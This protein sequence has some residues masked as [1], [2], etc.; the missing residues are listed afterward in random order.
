MGKDFTIDDKNTSN[1]N[2]T[3]TELYLKRQTNLA[4]QFT[5]NKL[6]KSFKTK[7]LPQTM[8]TTIDQQYYSYP[9]GLNRIDTA[10]IDNDTTIPPLRV[11]HNQTEW[12]QINSGP[13]TSGIPSHIF[14]RSRD[15]GLFPIPKAAYTITLTG[16]FY[17]RNMYAADYSTGTVAITQNS[18]TVTGTGT[19]FTSEMVGRYLCET[20]SNGEPIGEFYKIGAFVSTTSLTLETV[21]EE[22]SLS[23]ATYLIGESPNL[24]PEVH[25]LIPYRVA[26]IY[27]GT[28]RRSASRAQEFSNFYW[29][30]DWGN[31]N[32]RGRIEGGILGFIQDYAL[33]GSDNSQLLNLNEPIRHDFLSEEWES[34]ST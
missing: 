17:P 19:T 22:S 20:D 34:V 32:R 16:R 24:P 9:P 14:M 27:Y 1:S 13:V 8:S 6:K 3:N 23:G 28:K 25:E 4:V 30:G 15:F 26:S 10:T 21:F 18:A 11:V 12:D 31:P 7:N 2:L 5:L 33:H 29:T